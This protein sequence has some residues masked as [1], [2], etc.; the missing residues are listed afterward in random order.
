MQSDRKDPSNHA[1]DKRRHKRFRSTA[2]LGTPL[3]L[4]PLP[5]FFG[6]PLEGQVIDLSGGG[7]A[8]LINKELPANTKMHME[9]K[10]P[11]GA[12]LACH[13]MVRRTSGCTGGY[14]TGIEFLDLPEPMIS[15]IDKMAQD[16][17]A[18]DDRIEREETPVCRPECNF[19][20]VCDKSQKKAMDRN[21]DISILMKLRLPS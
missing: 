7:M 14:L 13:V 3:L 19:F 16:Y 1:D 15:Q 21:E 2:F 12:V 9:L 17:N 8:V 10:F 6:L 18:C 4:T 20:S 5:P 11:K